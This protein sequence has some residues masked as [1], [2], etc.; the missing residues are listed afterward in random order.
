MKIY[1]T[2]TF[3]IPLPENHSFPK[4]KYF[5]LRMRILEELRGR[6][7]EL[8]VPE[9]AS[10]EDILRAHEP[11]YVRRL[12][13]GELSDKE[14]RRVGLPWSPEIVK[15]S[16]ISAVAPSTSPITSRTSGDSLWSALVLSAN[17][18]GAFSASA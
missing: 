11:D 8:R 10:D 6:P 4:D 17:A 12:L 18:K 1:Y 16:T 2:D 9:P 14:I 15:S 13:N 7:V 3:P 5:L